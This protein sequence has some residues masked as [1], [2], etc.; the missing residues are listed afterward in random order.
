MLKRTRA[1]PIDSTLD[2]PVSCVSGSA[3]GTCT[4]TFA[5]SVERLISPLGVHKMNPSETPTVPSRLDKRGGRLENE[6]LRDG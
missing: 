3:S 6:R 5:S 4:L 1:G 2:H